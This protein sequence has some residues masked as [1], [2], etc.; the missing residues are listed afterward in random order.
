MISPEIN[1]RIFCVGWRVFWA[2]SDVHGKPPVAM[3]RIFAGFSLQQDRTGGAGWIR[4]PAW[5]RTMNL[6]L[7]TWRSEAATGSGC[8][9]S[10]RLLE[11]FPS[12]FR[13]VPYDGF[14]AGSGMYPSGR[15]IRRL[16]S[17]AG[18]TVGHLSGIHP[19]IAALA[20]YCSMLRVT[21]SLVM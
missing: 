7:Q 17:I 5:I 10:S 16:T 3:N 18:P 13:A 6:E 2:M 4:T 9:C 12:E 20:A 8:R 15:P 14:I 21:S 1:F 11:S 19:P